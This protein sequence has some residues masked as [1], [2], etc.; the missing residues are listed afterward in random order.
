MH[1]YKCARSFFR[2]TTSTPAPTPD[3][4]LSLLLA[5]KLAHILE[6]LVP[7]AQQLFVEAEDAAEGG[8]ELGA[9]VPDLPVPED[10]P[11][12]ADGAGVVGG[13]RGPVGADLEP[14]AEP[15]AEPLEV[16]VLVPG[17]ALLAVAEVLGRDELDLPLL[18][19][20][21][22]D[23]RRVV[24]DADVR[25]VPSEGGAEVP[26]V[27]HVREGQVVGPDVGE[28]RVVALPDPRQRDARGA[29]L[30]RVPQARL[31]VVPD[32]AEP[33]GVVVADEHQALDSLGLVAHPLQRPADERRFGIG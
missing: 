3:A 16:A 26:L 22:R 15:V 21:A 14:G 32:V 10:A 27:E 4:L 13:G 19:A 20:H 1:A 17:V 2:R 9:V 8:R 11:V 30:E 5:R 7:K 12:E 31:D 29:G 6:D 24:V 18:L 25:A 23:R 28:V 33:A